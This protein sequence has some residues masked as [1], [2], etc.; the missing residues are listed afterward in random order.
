MIPP[1]KGT[2]GSGVPPAKGVALPP[3]N[4]S[5]LPKLDAKLAGARG[6]DSTW[7]TWQEF[8]FRGDIPDLR[9]DDPEHKQPK[10]GYETHV[11]VYDLSNPEHLDHYEK[12]WQMAANSTV[13]I[14]A[15]ERT[16]DPDTKNWRVFL[17]WALAY[18]YAAKAQ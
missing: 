10:I 5:R 2:P 3:L 16:Y 1:E 4:G 12:V 6:Q 7:P 14:S 18:A 9:E 11:T 17:R 13:I 15:E 8:P